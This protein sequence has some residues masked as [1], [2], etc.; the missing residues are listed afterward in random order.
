MTDLEIEL[1]KAVKH[2]YMAISGGQKITDSI[3][4]C[5]YT[6][7]FGD[8]FDKCAQDWQNGKEIQK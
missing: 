2:C 1:L 5:F 7:E 6:Q 3:K 8:T 4:R